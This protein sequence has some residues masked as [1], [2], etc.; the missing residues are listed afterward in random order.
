MQAHIL[1]YVLA[2]CFLHDRILV[3]DVV[4]EL[5]SDSNLDFTAFHSFW[6]RIDELAWLSFALALGSLLC[7]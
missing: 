1:R 4:Y 2:V 5:G 3:E 7:E 6:T